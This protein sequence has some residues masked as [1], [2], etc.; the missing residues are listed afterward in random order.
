MIAKHFDI[1]V[2][3]L[4]GM[5]PLTQNTHALQHL[6]LTTAACEKLISGEINGDTLS[7]VMEH[8][9]FVE[10]ITE[11][12]AYFNDTRKEAI[13]IT[14]EITLYGTALMHKY[15]HKAKHPDRVHSAAD[16]LV[17]QTVDAE[18]VQLDSISEATVS[19]LKEVK[20]KI[21]QEIADPS[22]VGNRRPA[23][24]VSIKRIAEIVEE[25]RFKSQLSP[26]EQVDYCVNHIID[27][28]GKRAA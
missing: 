2:D 9:R 17:R 26:K 11:T 22:L 10:L 16:E 27:E 12:E 15:A 23:T 20:A 18:K 6:H 25:A 14:N 5:T 8:D 7:R 21:D 1:S 13:T 19:I 28:V 24:M 4:L 3:Y